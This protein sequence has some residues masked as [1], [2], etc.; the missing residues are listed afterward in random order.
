M[1]RNL[2]LTAFLG[3]NLAFSG[4]GNLNASQCNINTV[5]SA[6]QSAAGLYLL[7]LIWKDMKIHSARNQPMF[8]DFLKTILQSN[9]VSDN[10]KMQIKRLHEY[11]KG[12]TPENL[13]LYLTSESGFYGSIVGFMALI[14]L[15]SAY[16]LW[17]KNIRAKPT[18][19]NLCV[20]AVEFVATTLSNDLMY[21]FICISD[22]YEDREYLSCTAYL[23]YIASSLGTAYRLVV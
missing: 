14:K 17:N 9:D 21:S 11:G 18:F 1:K 7:T 19:S 13:L 20:A 4:K 15:V 6:T 10:Y 3:L 8:D 12:S 23:A 5:L 16:Q 2:L 22:S